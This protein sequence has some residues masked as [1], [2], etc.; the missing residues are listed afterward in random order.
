MALEA[1]RA[2]EVGGGKSLPD[3]ASSRA[4]VVSLDSWTLDVARRAIVRVTASEPAE[5]SGDGGGANRTGFG[6]VVNENGTVLTAGRIV[7]GTTKVAVVL[8][9]GRTLPVNSVVI[10]SL[11]DLAVLRVSE[12]RLRAMPLGSSGD[13]RVGDPLITLGGPVG[14]EGTGT[15]RA[16]GSANGGDLVADAR[17]TG[18][19]RSGLP[20]LNARGE[21][22]GIVTHTS[23]A[24]GGASLEFAVPIDRAKRVLR[25]LGPTARVALPRASPDINSDR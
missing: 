19:P 14:G 5:R 8:S 1:R 15:V 11:N 25:D 3:L 16:T 12:G 13:L 7:A 20:L 17:L 23:E 10:D 24:R 9:D 22:V 6:F 18:L 4:L 2:P 21:A